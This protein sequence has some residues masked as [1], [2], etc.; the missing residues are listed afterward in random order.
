M[1]IN[2]Q[3]LDAIVLH[4]MTAREFLQLCIDENWSNLQTIV[5]AEPG[6]RL[7][8][9]TTLVVEIPTNEAKKMM[10]GAADRI[11]EQLG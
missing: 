7:A 2:A 3:D 5:Q 11:G 4:T 1:M 8:F 6:S 10:E 9:M